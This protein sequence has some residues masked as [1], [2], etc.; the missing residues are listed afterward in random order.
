MMSATDSNENVTFD[1]KLPVII[2]NFQFA[3]ADRRCKDQFMHDNVWT[4]HIHATYKSSI[5][6]GY[7]FM[8]QELSKAL[9]KHYGAN[10]MDSHRNLSG[11][12]CD[13]FK[14]SGGT[15]VWCYKAVSKKAEGSEWFERGDYKLNWQATIS[16]PRG[17]VVR[18]EPLMKEHPMKK[19]RGNLLN[20]DCNAGSDVSTEQDDQKPSGSTGSDD[21][22]NIDRCRTLVFQLVI[23]GSLAGS[24]LIFGRCAVRSAFFT[25]VQRPFTKLATHNAVQ[26]D[27]YLGC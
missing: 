1:N 11:V 7:E 6:K 5:P 22:A 9:R 14:P 26:Y 17:T 23:V 27:T 12:F 15:N 16:L 4:D 8:H 18:E 2:R 20:N 3:A 24:P 10:N 25:K 19:R 21:E 13:K